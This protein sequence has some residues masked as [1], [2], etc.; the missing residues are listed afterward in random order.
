M[1]KSI[2]ITTTILLT[3]AIFSS[4]S[5]D[6]DIAIPATT[7]TGNGGGTTPT[8][9]MMH[10]HPSWGMGTEFHLDSTFTLASSVGGVPARQIK[11]STAKLYISKLAFDSDTNGT[12][13]LVSPNM[14]MYP[15]GPVNP[16]SYTS[17]SFN[18]GLDAVTNHLDPTQAPA[19]LN[20][21]DMHW[22]WN[23]SAGYKFV[24]LEGEVDTSATGTGN[25][26]KNFSY[27][28]A[29]DAMLRRVT[30]SQNVTF[31]ASQ[32]HSLNYHVMWNRFF[33][34]VD[35]ATNSNGHG[36]TPTNTII[37]NNAQSVFMVMP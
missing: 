31:T 24:K 13:L 27:H 8:T 15:I 7:E 3:A 22:N 5:K 11:F 12:Y 28:V 20:A 6:E 10:L 35:I 32:G 26:W 17:T 33:D 2:L 14:H 4:C 25:E 34:G 16:G 30:L 9:A 37:A 18:V 36:G 21:M 19:P 29:T 23:T 1:K